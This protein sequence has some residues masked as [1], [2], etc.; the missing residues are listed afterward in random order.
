MLYRR[1]KDTEDQAAY[2]KMLHIK[3]IA[4][5]GESVISSMGSQKKMPFDFDMLHFLP[6]QLFKI[7]LEKDDPVNTEIC[8]GPSSKRP[9]RLSSPIMIT[10]MSLGAVSKNLKIIFANV[11]KSLK[12]AFN[13]GEG[14]ILEQ[15]LELAGSFL[16]GQYCTVKND[17]DMERLARVAAV[18]IRFGQGAY[19][20]WESYLPPE[21]LSPAIAD[22]RG[23]KGTEP[24]YSPAHHYDIINSAQL[25]ARIKWIRENT[26]GVPVGAKIGCG[27]IERDIDMLIE[28]GA[29]FIALDGFGG[30]TGA[31]ENFVRENVGLPII[32]ALPR[33]AKHIEKAGLKG[34]ITLIASGGLRSSA[35]FAKCLALGA[36]AVYTGTAAL[37]AVNCDQYRVCHTGFCPTGI[38]TH[39]PELV[40]QLSVEEGIRKLSNF[41]KVST[42]EIANLARI[43]G[44]NDIGLLD[45]SDLFSL[46][47]DLAKL[48]GLRWLDGSFY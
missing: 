36:D 33:A 48:A 3:E 17:V 47:K 40:K 19:P 39:S 6:A 11:A 22:I 20:G 2:N 13:S 38:T 45:G 44:K 31:T 42:D 27:N 29:D 34:K 21:K 9:L 41:V 46:D 43:V 24:V 16:I 32:S 25:K 12:I 14:G 35:D 18:E 8:I 4:E 30:G 37:I 1:K 23:I 7:P 26:K 15:E 5:T 10:G 28:A